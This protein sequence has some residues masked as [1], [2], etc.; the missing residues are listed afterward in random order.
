MF[1][2]LADIDEALVAAI[3]L[4]GFLVP[5]KLLEL[6]THIRGVLIARMLQGWS[7]PFYG[8]VLAAIV[9]VELH[10]ASRHTSSSTAPSTTDE[11]EQAGDEGEDRHRGRRQ[12]ESHH[13]GET[14]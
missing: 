7:L 5:M 10:R 3:V 6:P 1:E 9:M 13:S 4:S 11:D 8:A 2:Y 12:P 14:I